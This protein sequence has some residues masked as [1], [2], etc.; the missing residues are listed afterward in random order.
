MIQ[1]AVNTARA[2][3][4]T[5]MMSFEREIV[6]IQS[7]TTEEQLLAIQVMLADSL[8]VN[9]NK[10]TPFELEYTHLSADRS[11]QTTLLLECE[12]TVRTQPVPEQVVEIKDQVCNGMYITTE[13]NEP[14][15]YETK[16]GVVL[17]LR[18]RMDQQ[19]Q[20]HE[21]M[22]LLTLWSQEH[23]ED[24]VGVYDKQFEQ[25]GVR[26][27]TEE[28]L[29]YKL[30]MTGQ[31]VLNAW[32]TLVAYQNTQVF[33]TRPVGQFY[34]GSHE[35]LGQASRM[36]GS[37]THMIYEL[38]PLNRVGEL[39][40]RTLP[41]PPNYTLSLHAPMVG[42]NIVTMEYVQMVDPRDPNAPIT[43][44][45]HIL[46]RLIYTFLNR[47]PDSGDDFFM[48]KE[49]Q[50][51]IMMDT[52]RDMERNQLGGAYRLDQTFWEM[53]SMELRHLGLGGL[54]S[55]FQF[56][57]VLRDRINQKNALIHAM[58]KV[59]FNQEHQ[60]K[61]LEG[62]QVFIPRIPNLPNLH[63]LDTMYIIQVEGHLPD[64]YRII[65][66]GP[67]RFYQAVLEDISTVT[68]E[69]EME[70][71]RMTAV[72]AG[73]SFHILSILQHLSQEKEDH[74]DVHAYNRFL[75]MR[76]WNLMSTGSI[77]GNPWGGDSPRYVPIDGDVLGKY[78]FRLLDFNNA[79]YTQ[80]STIQRVE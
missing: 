38:V 47:M 9:A 3:H 78:R 64:M 73:I 14:K 43:H 20:C 56:N 12:P 6:Q 29:V 25:G 2:H 57:N 75:G 21:R 18:E 41:S 55:F 72:Q 79:P 28:R 5:V 67:T 17:I 70:F 59:L 60:F 52:I 54:L 16:P 13:M 40:P 44:L 74:N 1:Y 37:E 11:S 65:L 24:Y 30:P 4:T 61:D 27:N 19:G 31:W 62:D 45:A 53:A 76:I 51:D 23:F 49:A 42:V 7:E 26:T 8:L 32:N 69:Q 68:P 77:Q 39:P 33:Y 34:I 36:H 15:D 58:S 63:I 71:L 22:N 46:V 50:A 10:N 66:N 35:R 80:L 48:S